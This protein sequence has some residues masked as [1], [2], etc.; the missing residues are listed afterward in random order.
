M[1]RRM[2]SLLARRTYTAARYHLLPL[3]GHEIM[4]RRRPER[5]LSEW[6]STVNPEG[7]ISLGS[8]VCVFVH[9]D[10][11][12]DVRPH[13]LHQV[14]AFCEAGISVVF[15]TN[16]AMLRPEP[17]AKLQAIC[18]AI[19]IRQN[20]GYDFGAWREGLA[21][22]ALPR[23]DTEMVIIANDSVYG[24]VRPLADVLSHI[25]FSTADVWGCTDTWQHRYHL[26]SYFMA[27]S[28]AVLRSP[29]W[30]AFWQGVR[31]T[32]SKNWL[33]RLYEVGL[34][35][36]LL[37]AGFNCQAIWP[38]QTLVEDIDCD[39]LIDYAEGGPNLA[40]AAVRARQLQARR[41][42]AA[43][44]EHVALNPTSDLWRQLLRGGYPFI[45]REL[46]RDNPTRVPDVAEW[47][48]VLAETG[49]SMRGTLGPIE[50]DLQR[51]LKNRAP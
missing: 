15:V 32:W 23:P 30:Q 44:V 17:M 38:Y 31:P 43:A 28:P 4:R 41:L 33:I 39:M 35:Q 29:V 3:L 45:K 13:V 16:S 34:T 46:L 47:R 27:F 8:R 49:G 1:F 11:A 7:N 14:Q 22:L 51:T 25:D 48:A 18:A 10:G 12:G 36:S 37:K 42:R 20:V 21:R 40:D 9:W 50:L 26:Q 2:G 5:L 6:V 24:P 19:M